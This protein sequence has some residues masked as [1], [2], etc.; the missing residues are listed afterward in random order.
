ME[1]NLKEC[2]AGLKSND[3]AACCQAAEQ[4]LQPGEQ[5]APA[6]VPLIGACA[7][8]SDEVRELAAAALE[9]IGPPAVADI[10]RLGE[11]AGI[12]QA[13]AVYW[14]ATLLGRLGGETAA[15][16]PNLVGALCNNSAP[17][18]NER[19]AWALGKI[20]PEAQPAFESLQKLANGDSRLAR[21][22]ANALARIEGRA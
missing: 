4:L 20:G 14:A 16:V 3:A 13:D 2:I 5:A 10:G 18:T 22:A 8:E 9:N 1:L 21:T 7:H 17:A 11:L 6:A 12:E 15:A 19:I